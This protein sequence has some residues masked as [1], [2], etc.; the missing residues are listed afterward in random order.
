MYEHQF[1]FNTVDNKVLET[2]VSYPWEIKLLAIWRQA[3]SHLHY[4]L[5]GNT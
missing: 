1:N 2:N 4:V 3:M 5:S